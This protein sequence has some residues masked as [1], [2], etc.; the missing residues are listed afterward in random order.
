MAVVDIVVQM[1]S[2]RSPNLEPATEAN[3]AIVSK[4]TARHRRAEA[5]RRVSG[6]VRRGEWAITGGDA[7]VYQGKLQ[8]VPVQSP[9]TV[10][11]F[12]S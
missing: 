1:L 2:A 10:I 5:A 6:P 7:L 4:A 3:T 12:L 9:S 8:G 11:R